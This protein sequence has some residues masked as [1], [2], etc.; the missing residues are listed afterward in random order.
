MKLSKTNIL[1]RLRL[2][3]YVDLNF[4][5]FVWLL[6]HLETFPEIGDVKFNIKIND[7]KITLS[8]IKKTGYLKA[9]VIVVAGLSL[10]ILY[11]VLW[12]NQS[13]NK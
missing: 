7:Q 6:I 10:N 1:E 5:R 12:R 9:S 3:Q 13:K 2:G 11:G 8:P 4:S